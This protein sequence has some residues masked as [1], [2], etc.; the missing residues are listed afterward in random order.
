MAH[1]TN[2]DIMNIHKVGNMGGIRISRQ[3]QCIVLI[4]NPNVHKYSDSI[5]NDSFEIMYD[6]AFRKG[7]KDQLMKYN[8]KTLADTRL[9]LHVYYGSSDVYKY[10]GVYERYGDYHTTYNADGRRVF[11][12][13]IRKRVNISYNFDSFEY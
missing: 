6:G 8:N 9:P 2:R 1:F 4:I 5:L 3:T 13:P 10:M 11:V 12:F 7:S